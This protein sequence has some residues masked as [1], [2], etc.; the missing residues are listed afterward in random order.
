MVQ[1]P[2]RKNF[3]EKLN[4]AVDFFE[5]N[6]RNLYNNVIAI[7]HNDA[8]GISSLQIIQNLLHKMNIN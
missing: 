5:D 6:S 4:T 3:L 2:D 1:K 7:S 8:D